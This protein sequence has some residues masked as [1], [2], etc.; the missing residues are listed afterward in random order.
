MKT[1]EFNLNGKDVK[2]EV[3]EDERLLDMLRD[4]LMLTGTKEG[5]G[6]GECGACTVI[7]DG[8]AVNSC[9]TFAASVDGKSV[10]TIEGVAQNG[11]LAPIQKS[12]LEHNALQCGFCTPGIVMSIKALLDS[13][14]KPTEEEI[15]IAISGN[16]CRCTGYQQIL[17]AVEDVVSG[18]IA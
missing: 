3:P 9:L 10:I 5:C 18:K 14:P 7:V 6:I 1:I 4:R 17:E 13:N 11:E 12:I 2:I 8:V 16:L 15:K